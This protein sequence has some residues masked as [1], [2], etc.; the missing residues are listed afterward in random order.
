[1]RAEAI[2]IVVAPEPATGAL[3]TMLEW[4]AGSG[5]EVHVVEDVP[6]A[7]QHASRTPAQPPCIL[8]DLRALGVGSEIED[9][10]LACERVRKAAHAIAHSTPIAITGSADAGIAIALF[11]AGA[12]DV[13][14]IQL[15]GHGASKAVIQ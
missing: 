8:L 12:G 1:M 15:E 5:I 3:R 9:V 10:K 2:A 7:A 6:T 11:R 13:I 4:L 14:D